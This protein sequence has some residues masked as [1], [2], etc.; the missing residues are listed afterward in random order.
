[1]DFVLFFP[2]YYKDHFLNS[3]SLLQAFL[4]LGL[5]SLQYYLYFHYTYLLGYRHVQVRGQLAG[6]GL[7]LPC[8][9]PDQTQA[10]RFGRKHFYPPRYLATLIC[11]SDS[12]SL[13]LYYMFWFLILKR[14]YVYLWAH[15]CAGGLRG[16]KWAARGYWIA[17]PGVNT[18]LGIAMSGQNLGPLKSSQC[19]QPP[20]HLSSPRGQDFYQCNR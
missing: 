3:I 14:F 16:Q 6:V 9:S 12:T 5:C 10:L 7:H 19:S 4:G 20:S 8:R 18:H 13:W 15:K 1:M 2:I 17:G 11:I